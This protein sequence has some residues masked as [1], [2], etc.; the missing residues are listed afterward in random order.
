MELGNSP[1]FVSGMRLFTE[2]TSDTVLY[3]VC[4]MMRMSCVVLLAKNSLLLWLFGVWS[5]MCAPFL[6]RFSLLSA[7]LTAPFHSSSCNYEDILEL[8]E[9]LLH[10]LTNRMSTSPSET[11][12]L[13]VL[14][15]LE[16][17]PVQS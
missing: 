1:I 6:L 7:A 4:K 8:A 13:F 10:V 12:E 11:L 2:T 9:L 15:S 17:S 16:Q 14:S 3:L 5:S